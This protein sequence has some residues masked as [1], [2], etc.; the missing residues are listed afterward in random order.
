M[1]KCSTRKVVLTS[2]LR[3][4]RAWL[5]RVCSLVPPPFPET[6]VGA[7]HGKREATYGSSNAPS[8]PTKTMQ[9]LVLMDD[10]YG[11]MGHGR[12]TGPA[13]GDRHL[14]PLGL[15]QKPPAGGGAANGTGARQHKQTP[16]ARPA[17]GS[18]PSTLP[19]PP[20]GPPVIVLFP[21]TLHLA[22]FF[23]PAPPA[24]IFSAVLT[25]L[26][27]LGAWVWGW[28]VVSTA[29]AGS[30]IAAGF[31]I[32]LGVRSRP[33]GGWGYAALVGGSQFVFLSHLAAALFT[34]ARVFSFPRLLTLWYRGRLPFFR[35]LVFGC[36]GFE[37]SRF[38]L[39]RVVGTVVPSFSPTAALLL[40]V[41]RE[42]VSV[43]GQ[44]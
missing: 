15:V 18:C 35:G 33:V 25:L 42:R 38:E 16:P 2:V 7:G 23:V 41:V 29:G 36:W 21:A 11:D 14:L 28:G 12:P 26:A 44:G 1:L 8:R 17:V 9:S 3:S 31:V 20:E 27:I 32:G 19:P 40:L 37:S 13:T 30:G 5:L 22:I 4:F 24:T 43:F 34:P 39:T 10:S 6:W